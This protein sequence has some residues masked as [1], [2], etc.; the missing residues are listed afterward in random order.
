MIN[1]QHGNLYKTGKFHGYWKKKYFGH[2]TSAPSSERCQ[3]FANELAKLKPFFLP[4]FLASTIP[5]INLVMDDS[6]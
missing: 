6:A 2:F 1:D 4:L 5:P 3:I